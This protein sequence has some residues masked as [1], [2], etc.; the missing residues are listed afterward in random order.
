MEE[1]DLK[2]V[3]YYVK[4][5]SVDGDN[6]VKNLTEEVWKIQEIS[7]NYKKML[8]EVV[9][10]YANNS[11]LN[12]ESVFNFKELEGTFKFHLIKGHYYPKDCLT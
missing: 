5:N 3:Q 1:Y 6:K 4:L 11:S 9:Y 12:A 10:K 7:V 8:E 2:H